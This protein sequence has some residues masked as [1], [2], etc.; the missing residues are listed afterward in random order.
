[1]S[2]DMGICLSGFRKIP[3]SPTANPLIL[4]SELLVVVNVYFPL[5]ESKNMGNLVANHSKR[6]I[7]FGK[8]NPESACPS[9]TS[10]RKHNPDKLNLEVSKNLSDIL[11]GFFGRGIFH[12]VKLFELLVGLH[13]MLCRKPFPQLN[14]FV[15]DCSVSLLNWFPHGSHV[16]PFTPC[17]R[18]ATRNRLLLLIYYSKKVYEQMLIN[19]NAI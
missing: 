18:T 7:F 17:Q 16:N 4:C 1:M 2:F 8:G 11:V 15:N 3:F 12:A 6:N 10:I 14:V 19:Q 5:V 13:V 9:P